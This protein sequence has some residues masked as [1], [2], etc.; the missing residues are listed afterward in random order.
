M[1][2]ID[3]SIATK[4]FKP[5]ERHEAE[6]LDLIARIDHG[7]VQAGANEILGLEVVRALKNA[8]SRQ[9]AL[10]MTDARIEIAFE[11]L[12]KMFQGGALQMCTVTAAKT[13]TKE[14]EMGI[15][16]FMADAL[17]LAS[18]INMKASHFVV[19]D[20]HFLTPAVASY[21]AGFGLQVV[22]LPDLIAALNTASSKTTPPTP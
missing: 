12:E 21:A 13:L 3:A 16:L 2:G 17:H 20:H 4:W 18:A 22:S 5:G 14:I 8:Q 7:G 9:P 19:D 1:I 6:A 10:G 11:R 15:G